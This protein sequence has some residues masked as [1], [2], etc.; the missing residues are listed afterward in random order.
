MNRAIQI[1]SISFILAL[2]SAVSAQ[3]PV[4]CGIVDIDGPTKVDPG[5]PLV[6][7]V[8]V[9]GLLESLRPEFKWFISAG[10]ISKGQGADE[11]TVDTSGL[12]GINLTTTVELQGAPSGC[13]SVAS[14]TV[15]ITLPP[16]VCGLAFDQYGDINFEYEQARLDNFVIQIFNSPDSSGLIHMSAG[17][18]TFK[19]EAAYRLARAKSYLVRFRGIDPSRIVTVDCGFTPDLRATLWVVP[20]GVTFPECNTLGQIPLSEVKFTKPRPNSLKKR[21]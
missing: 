7:K 19:R 10:E 9:S 13:K 6:F 3:T 2:A 20:P 8:K 21:R 11:I 12:G 14:K 1:L 4:T 16:P 5:T 15:Q 18:K 17:Q